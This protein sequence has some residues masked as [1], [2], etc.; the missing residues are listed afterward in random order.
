ML[1]DVEAGREL[2]IEPLVGSFVELGRLTETP[3]PA[4]DMVY[5][6]TA[7]LNATLTKGVS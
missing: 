3:T 7:L 5:A 1:Q 6:L 4:T 2:E